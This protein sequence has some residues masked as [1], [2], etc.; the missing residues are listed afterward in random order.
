MKNYE[1]KISECD[2]WYVNKLKQISEDYL[3]G[4]KEDWL[5]FIGAEKEN[6]A[7]DT[8]MCKSNIRECAKEI[9]R[10]KKLKTLNSFNTKELK[11]KSDT[12]WRHYNY[13]CKQILTK[14]QFP[15]YLENGYYSKNAITKLY[16]DTE[17][18][19]DDYEKATSKRLEELRKEWEQQKCNEKVTQKC[20]KSVAK[21]KKINYI[22]NTNETTTN[23]SKGETTM[24]NT[25]ENK[26]NELLTLVKHL[27]ARIESLELGNRPQ[28]KK[29]RE[30]KEEAP[31]KTVEKIVKKTAEKTAVTSEKQE[32]MKLQKKARESEKTLTKKQMGE[33]TKLITE[34]CRE[35]NKTI[36]KTDKSARS[37][38][39]VKAR[40]SCLKKARAI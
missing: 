36:A 31:K 37:I 14:N 23:N 7:I 38:A 15:Y 27:N 26:I 13:M 6:P 29:L 18:W 8:K 19:I 9:E 3:N 40:I 25:M 2:D 33:Y 21:P 1:T 10:R 20:E 32:L 24:E 35:I 4:K 34:K 11:D 30:K 12:D 28:L 39:F 5:K 16:N 22:N 17:K